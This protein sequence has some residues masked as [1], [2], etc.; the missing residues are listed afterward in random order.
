MNVGR[1]FKAARMELGYTQEDVS[2]LA[3]ISLGYYSNIER[4]IKTPSI[5]V[6]INIS[7]ALKIKPDIF[8]DYKYKETD[9]DSLIVKN[10]LLDG[11]T[12]ADNQFLSEMMIAMAKALK[13]RNI[14]NINIESKKPPI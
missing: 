14:S 13:K 9:I 2:R 6:F 4:E 5:D 7:L 10:E 1:L 3:N 11:L 12:E 8:K